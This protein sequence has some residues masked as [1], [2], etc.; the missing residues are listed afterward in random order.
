MNN[1]TQTTSFLG[2]GGGC[3]L[4][5]VLHNY[6]LQPFLPQIMAPDAGKYKRVDW[7]GGGAKEGWIQS[8]EMD[9]CLPSEK[10]IKGMS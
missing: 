6:S 5:S 8:N 9:S 4:T 1:K 10:N 7:G 3:I 2:G